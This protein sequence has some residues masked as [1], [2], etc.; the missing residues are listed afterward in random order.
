MT[1]TTDEARDLPVVRLPENESEYASVIPGGG[2]SVSPP[3]TAVLARA[4]RRGESHLSSNTRMTE[5]STLTLTFVN[6]FSAPVHGRT[7]TAR[8]S[9]RLGEGLKKKRHRV[10]IGTFSSEEK[11]ARAWDAYVVE[12]KLE[13]PLNFPVG[14]DGRPPR[15]SKS[16]SHFNLI[17]LRFHK[18]FIFFQFFFVFQIFV[19]FFLPF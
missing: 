3:R 18:I 10:T 13:R 12:H 14:A 5:L 15:K 7:W 16:K 17:L 6:L 19:F 4:Q 2:A 8:I 1:M 9:Y 11:A